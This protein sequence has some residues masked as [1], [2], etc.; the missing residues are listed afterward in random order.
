MTAWRSLALHHVKGGRKRSSTRAHRVK[1]REGGTHAHPH[2]GGC[3]L[4]LA[5]KRL[6]H[7][8]VS[9]TLCAS[10][11][12]GARNR[13]QPQPWCPAAMPGWPAQPRT[14]TCRA[15]SPSTPP[16]STRPPAPAPHQ[17]PCT[18]SSGRHG[19]CTGTAGGATAAAAAAA[20]A[21]TAAGRADDSQRAC[22]AAAVPLLATLAVQ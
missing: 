22:V 12:V 15:P 18:P 6:L 17:T 11:D 1:G 14:R 20:A 13:A 16:H 7:G 19:Q 2:D 10:A 8:C 5:G 4:Q 9:H 21:A 3:T